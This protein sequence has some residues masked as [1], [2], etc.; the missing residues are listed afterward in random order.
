MTYTALRAVLGRINDRIG[1]NVTLHDLRHT[2]CLRLIG[3]P[4]ISLVDAQQVMRHR[5]I[6]TTGSYLRP[7]P[8]EVIAK[9]HE[10]YTK[11]KSAPLPLDGWSYDPQDL[12][13]VFGVS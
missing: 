8:D 5:R 10:H 7:R 13:D 12:A 1:A 2:L 3:D 9:V 11:P 4:D 6:T